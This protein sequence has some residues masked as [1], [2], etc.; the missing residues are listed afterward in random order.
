MSLLLIILVDYWGQCD[1][2][3][4]IGKVG[5]SFQT[6]DITCQNSAHIL[7]IYPANLL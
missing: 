6:I 4:M 7:A 1:R 2:T 3:T 5:G